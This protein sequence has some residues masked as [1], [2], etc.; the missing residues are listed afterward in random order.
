MNHVRDTSGEAVAGPVDRLDRGDV[1][2]FRC[3]ERISR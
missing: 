3:R 1:T 2:T